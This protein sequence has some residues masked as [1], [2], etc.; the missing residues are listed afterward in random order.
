MPL[1]DLDPGLLLAAWLTGLAGGSGHCLGMCG[2][3]LAAFGTGQQTGWRGLGILLCAHCGRVLGYALAGAIVGSLGGGLAAGLLGAHGAMVLR[4]VAAALIALIGL[5]LLLGR[6]LLGRLERLGGMFWMRIA[7]QLKPLWPPRTPLRALAAG[8]LWGWLPCG[9]VYAQLAVAAASGGAVHGALAMAFFG[10]GTIIS[11]SLL[12]TLLHAAG[13]ARLPTRASGAL[14]I[15]FAA[16]T[17]FP[18]LLSSVRG[19]H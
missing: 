8:M 12:S 9:L 5:Q 1:A 14:L 18:V 19:M 13:L 7:P 3:I 6:P 11:L 17:V 4:Y 2:G 15:L 16:W 10:L